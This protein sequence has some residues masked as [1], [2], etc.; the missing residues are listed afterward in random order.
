MCMLLGAA[1]CFI[2]ARLVGVAL[3]PKCNVGVE[4]AAGAMIVELIALWLFAF[5]LG[6]RA[7]PQ[8]TR[9]FV[10]YPPRRVFRGVGAAMPISLLSGAAVG[11]FAGE[12][13]FATLLWSLV[14]FVAINLL[15]VWLFMASISGTKA[16]VE[17]KGDPTLMIADAYQRTW[18]YYGLSLLAS[19]GLCYWLI[20][21]PAESWFSATSLHAG[22]I[23]AVYAM[24]YASG[25]YP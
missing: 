8:D 15:A 6:V 11:A 17:R 14:G 16:G 3:A 24:G 1:A 22:M 10:E 5:A 12:S 4:G 21:G 13:V 7:R 18:S 9:Q 19:L 23:T 2:T 20:G 25:Y